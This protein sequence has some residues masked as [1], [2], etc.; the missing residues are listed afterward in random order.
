MFIRY[1][2]HTDE[3]P[4]GAIALDYLRAMLCF[5]VPIRLL[6]LSGTPLDHRGTGAWSLYRNLLTTPMSG[7]FINV[8]ATPRWVT[9][10]RFSM[11]N[12]DGTSEDV[13]EVREL[14]TAGVRNVLIQTCSADDLTDLQFEAAKKYDRVILGHR[15][16]SSH[17]DGDLRKF[18]MGSV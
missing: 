12:A 4:H 11:Q 5:D 17:W 7:H 9:E 8:V 6:S 16:P 10:F 2:A 15:Y 18:V 14:W 13:A 3:S 1:L